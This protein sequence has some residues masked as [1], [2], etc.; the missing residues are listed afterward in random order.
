MEDLKNV[1][2]FKH[3]QKILIKMKD[4][5]LKSVKNILCN[6]TRI[7]SLYPY[8]IEV[9]LPDILPGKNQQVAE[10]FKVKGNEFFKKGKNNSAIALYNQGILNC[11]KTTGEFLKSL[12]NVT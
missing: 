3:C 2:F 10:T 5:E 11:P 12:H 9:K 1:Y 4:K 8:C 7:K 6:E